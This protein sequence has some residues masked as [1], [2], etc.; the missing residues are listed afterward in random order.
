MINLI[1]PI[2]QLGYGIAGLNICKSLEQ[3]SDVA[4]WP[5]GPISGINQHDGQAL[6]RCIR[7]AQK[8]IFDAPCIKVWHQNDMAQFVGK[9]D[10]IGF[11]FFEL[12]N[13]SAIE[14]HHLNSLD[15]LFVSSSWAKKVVL[16]NTRLKEKQVCVVPLGVNS[17]VFQPYQQPSSHKNTIFFNCGKWE[18]RKGHDVLPIIFNNAFSEEDNVELWMMTSNPFLKEDQE[19]HWHHLYKDTKLGDKIK[20]ID[21][22]DTQKQVYNIMKE[23]DCGIFPSRAEGWNL[24]LLEMMSCGKHVICTDY[25]AHTEFCNTD[26][27][28]LINIDTQESA[29]DGFWFHGD[30]G[31]WSTI[32]RSQI[33]QAIN[34]MRHVHKQ[35]SNDSLHLNTNGIETAKKFS[36]ENTA[37]GIL[38]YV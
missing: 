11:P 34:H 8:P 17:D 12:D 13:F 32:G 22:V 29:Q 4:L 38:N 6:Q 19:R 10:H 5:I 37:K 35:K 25:S 20:F 26:N 18:K 1:A 2:N 24:E 30:V 23:A 31:N 3:L 16:E 7:N 15:K 28:L 21:R 9:G 27:A 33:D 36:W 14:K